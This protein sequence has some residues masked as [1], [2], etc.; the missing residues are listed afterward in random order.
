MLLMLEK[1]I[2]EEYVTLFVDMQKLR[3]NKLKHY[4]KIKNDHVFNI[5]MQVIY[6]VGQCCKSFQ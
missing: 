2:G 4:D 6:M 5:G 3:T 1:G